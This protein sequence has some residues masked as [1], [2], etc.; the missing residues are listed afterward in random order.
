MASDD[1]KPLTPQQARLKLQ[2]DS[3]RAEHLVREH[4]A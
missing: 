2:E 4:L 3:D 1:D